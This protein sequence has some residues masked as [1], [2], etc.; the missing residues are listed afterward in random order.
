[1]ALGGRTLPHVR[2]LPVSVLG[3]EVAADVLDIVG[4]ACADCRA[5]FLDVSEHAF[6]YLF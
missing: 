5:D 2:H 1:M 6:A 4:V 3:E